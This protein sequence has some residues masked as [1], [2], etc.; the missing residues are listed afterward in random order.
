MHGDVSIGPRDF[1]VLTSDVLSEVER[2][3]LLPADPP[4][5]VDPML[6]TLSAN[7]TRG[8]EWVYEPKLDGV[9]LVASRRGG[10]VH[11]RSRNRLPQEGTYPEIVDA[12]AAQP[13][14]DV[15]VDGEVV[16]FDDGVP[17]FSRLQGRM[18]INDPVRARR[19]G[20]EVAYCVFDLL[21][22]AGYDTTHLPTVARKRL[23]AVVLDVDVAG[24]NAARTLQ[25][26]RHA[27][28][29]PA[30]LLDLACQAGQEGLIAK[31]AA[32]PY[33]QKRSR[34]WLKLK[35]SRRQ[36]FVVG[37][38][39]DPEG[40]RTAFGSLLVGYYDEGDAGALTYAGKVGTG[41]SEAALGD[42]SRALHQR[43]RPD[44][45]FA[46]GA[47]PRKGVHWV[48]PDLVCEV[49]FTEWTRDGRL[50]HPRFLGLRSDKDARNVVR[51]EAV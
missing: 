20:I 51:E 4:S 47:P 17:S 13:C 37:G 30:V 45:P 31:R 1:D 26:V 9:R 24:A 15:V 23:L 6:A 35:C 10:D 21:Y 44:S 39:T 38:W 50:R 12:L 27:E 5:V 34:D 46:R 41:F 2:D 22:V 36:E 11:L 18:Q 19:S 28:G 29:D 42:L 32:A 49:A 43:A 3:R 8:N 16:A 48:E 25:L 14:D 40:S 33:Q 7:L